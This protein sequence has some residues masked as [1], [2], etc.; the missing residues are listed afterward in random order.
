M[1]ILKLLDTSFCFVLKYFKQIDYLHGKRIDPKIMS[2]FQH[3]AE[4]FSI[5]LFII[6]QTFFCFLI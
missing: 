5:Y 6:I 3:G 1:S 2:Y 4:E